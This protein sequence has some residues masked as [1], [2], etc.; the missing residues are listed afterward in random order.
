M[1]G[2]CRKGI[3]SKTMQNPVF[4]RAGNFMEISP[5]SNFRFR[6]RIPTVKCQRCGCVEKAYHFAYPHL[7]PAATLEQQELRVIDEKK[8]K[9]AD[10]A[11]VWRIIDKL[12]ERW[13][14]PITAGTSFG[15]YEIKVTSTPK[16]DFDV[17]PMGFDL[18]V[19]EPAADKLRQLGFKFEDVIPRAFG[20]HGEAAAFVQV[21]VPVI[22]SCSVPESDAFCPM[23]FRTQGPGVRKEPGVLYRVPHVE[24]APFFK[25][26]EWPYLVF[27]RE[28]VERANG[29]G[30]KGLVEG[31]TIFPIRM[32]E[33][34]A[35]LPPH[36]SAR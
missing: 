18:F 2:D 25:T 24:S 29:A 4:Y 9:P 32:V 15:A 36:E 34:P 35:A 13:R 27:S 14:V 26:V 28:L 8:P 3:I 5:I 31:K 30:L 23:C 12:R 11:V 16:I 7:D 6:Y 33:K 19:R 20:K 1:C 22:G 10:D 17:F 21:V